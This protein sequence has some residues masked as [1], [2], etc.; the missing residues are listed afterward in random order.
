MRLVQPRGPCHS[1][2]MLQGSEHPCIHMSA[3]TLSCTRAYIISGEIFRGFTSHAMTMMQEEASAIDI[4]RGPFFSSTSPAASAPY[5]LMPPRSFSVYQPVRSHTFVD[6]GLSGGLE[7]L[8]WSEARASDT[9]QFADSVVDRSPHNSTRCSMVQLRAS[10]FPDQS[11]APPSYNDVRV[12]LTTAGKSLGN[13]HKASSSHLDTHFAVSSLPQKELMNI[14]KD[15]ASEWVK[16]WRAGC[17]SSSS[18]AICEVSGNLIL[19]WTTGSNGQFLMCTHLDVPG[20]LADPCSSLNASLPAFDCSSIP[21]NKIQAHQ[22][23]SDIQVQ[24]HARLKLFSF[25]ANSSSSDRCLRSASTSFCQV[26]LLLNL[27][28][29]E[30]LCLMHSPGGVQNFNSIIY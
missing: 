17:N 13:C 12:M 16:E 20:A 23:I 4:Q 6:F 30:T 10:T 25:F 3:A 21:S 11:F 5:I 22:R 24:R 9:A 27:D 8:R 26:M 7:G 18:L 1:H 19:L 28:D 29:I 14:A 15:S 2:L